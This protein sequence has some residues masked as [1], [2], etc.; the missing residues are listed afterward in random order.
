MTVAHC[1]R[2]YS[3][4]LCVLC[5]VKI[6]RE[7]LH[8]CQVPNAVVAL[9][10]VDA[11]RYRELLHEI[12]STG[13]TLHRDAYRASVEEASGLFDRIHSDSPRFVQLQAR[14]CDHLM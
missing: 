13:C 10:H 12:E 4:A 8:D 5:V 2:L 7:L 1:M 9:T 11:T 6:H 3:S 14:D